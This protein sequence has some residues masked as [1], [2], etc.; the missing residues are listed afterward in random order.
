MKRVVTAE[1]MR[2]FERARFA[3]GRAESLEWMERAARGVDDVLSAR[4]SG[5][6]VLVVC[7]G[8]SN[9]GDGFALLRLLAAR[10]IVAE[11]ALL[12][13]PARLGGDARVN[14][15]RARSCG[16]PLLAGLT[17]EAL[18]RCEV[19]VDALLGTGLSRPA[20]GA[21][22]E[23]IARMNAA[24][25]P[26]VAVD[27]PSGVDATTGDVPGCA[28]RAETTVTFQFYK[29]AH[30]L[31]P[32][33]GLCG[34]VVLKALSEEPEESEPTVSL[35][36][37]ADAARLLPPRPADSHKGKNGRA[38]LCVGSAAY[39]GAALLSAGAALRGGA[40]LVSAAV[41]GE[42]KA[43]FS[44]LPEA[45]AL[46]VNGGGDWDDAACEQ[47]ARL[48]ERQDAVCI[49]CGVGRGGVLPLVRRALETRK[50]LVLD[51]DALN[52]LSCERS[53]FGMLHE[54]VVLTPHIAE[55]ARLTGEAA[56]TILADPIGISR[57]YAERWGCVVLLKSATS[58]VSNGQSVRLNTAG[59]PGLAKGGSGDVL[60]GLVTALLAQGL[61]PFDAASAGAFLLGASANEAFALL[62]SRMLNARDVIDVV[63]DTIGRLG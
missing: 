30:L 3:D 48:L 61:A 20:E 29:R 51:A 56:E 39:T 1:E 7:G 5:Q 19:I 16:V 21:Y 17:E 42:V 22:A 46:A 55:M 50:A 14:Y 31:F 45:C 53:L 44:A 13:E 37:R 43:A 59:N 18:E 12:C 24:G 10:G 34:D 54:R 49:G 4:Y 2:A 63:S 35:F 33:H 62:G 28:I 23:A 60:A 27:L 32:G 6:S 9:G 40:G 41:P 26:I 38:L 57:A 58:C 36:E 8:G 25:K 11:G 47:A 52:Q 15:L